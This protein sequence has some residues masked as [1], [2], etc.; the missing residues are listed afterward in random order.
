[1]RDRR[2]FAHGP[3]APSSPH[4]ES[5]CNVSNR[6][7]MASTHPVTGSMCQF[8]VP[9]KWVVS[10]CPA[11]AHSP[12]VPAAMCARC[13]W[14]PTESSTGRHALTSGKAVHSTVQAE[15]AVSATPPHPASEA[16]PSPPACP[17]LPPCHLQQSPQS[18]RRLRQLR[19]QHRQHG[20]SFYWECS[21]N[22]IRWMPVQN[23]WGQH[24]C[25]PL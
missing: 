18:Q 8:S 5:N 12:L 19:Q 13:V 11:A 17:V 10:R 21:S 14:S 25:I 20:R 3:Q 7:A 23:M 16:P 4:W 22:K 9:I 1:M 15:P 2:T 24:S 6:S